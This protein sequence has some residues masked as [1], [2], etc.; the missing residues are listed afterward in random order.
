MRGY[1]RWEKDSSIKGMGKIFSMSCWVQRLTN[2]LKI[3]PNLVQFGIGSEAAQKR[4][5]DALDLHG[6]PK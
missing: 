3:I 2:L 1:P 4:L 5:N 6:I